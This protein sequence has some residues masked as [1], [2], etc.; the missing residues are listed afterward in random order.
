MARKYVENLFSHQIH[1]RSLFTNLSSS[2]QALLNSHAILG[3]SEN[4]L[5]I[6]IFKF[7]GLDYDSDMEDGGN[8]VYDRTT[9]V[10]TVD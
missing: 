1:T 7:Q 10:N 3:S 2:L 4:Q 5:W 9:K 8:H 6:Q